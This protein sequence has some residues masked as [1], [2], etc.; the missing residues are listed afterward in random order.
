MREPGH[1]SQ[2]KKTNEREPGF[3]AKPFKMKTSVNFPLHVSLQKS[4]RLFTC[5]AWKILEIT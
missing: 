2:K 4:T 3:H 1:L 5:N